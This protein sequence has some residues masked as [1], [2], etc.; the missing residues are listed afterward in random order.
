MIR[1]GS[2]AFVF[3]GSGCGLILGLDDFEDAPA[4]EDHSSSGSSGTDTCRPDISERCYSG[5]SGTEDVG[6]CSSGMRTCDSSGE[7][8]GACQNEVLP[9]QESCASTEDENCDGFDCALWAKTIETLDSNARIH[10][11]AIDSKGNTI[12]AG[13][14]AGSIQFG[15]KPLIGSE[16]TEP[17]ALDAFIVSFDSSGSHRWSRQFSD[18]MNQ[19][20]TAVCVDGS[21]NVIVAGVNSGRIKLGGAEIGPGIFVAKF[22]SGG[23]HLWSRGIA[24]SP[25]GDSGFLAGL[26][27]VKSTPDGDLILAGHFTGTI[28]FDDTEFSTYPADSQDVYIARLDGNTG[29]L[30][31]ADGGWA[32]RFEGQGNDTLAGITVHSSNNIIVTGNFTSRIDFDNITPTIDNGMFL[33]NLDRTGSVTWARGFANAQPTALSVDTLGNISATGAYEHPTNFGGGDLPDWSKKAFA[34]QFNIAGNYRWSRGFRGNITTSDISADPLNNVAILTYVTHEVRLE[35]SEIMYAREVPSPLIIKLD[36]DGKTLWKRWFPA[37][38]SGA[39]LAG[40]TETDS[41]GEIVISGHT[42]Y[43]SD[44]TATIDFGSGP[45]PM[46]SY[47]LFIAKLGS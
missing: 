1:T 15:A 21:G 36:T 16:H 14:F 12:A 30:R 13:S 5:P 42:I 44:R 33:V 25:A 32:R 11:I 43:T 9:H 10:S 26:P 47:S 46:G 6:L 28:Q 23:D 4:S 37:E 18:G 39:G 17:S 20:A 29:S 22:N 45:Q 7:M 2:L 24:G 34:V 41:S 19:E 3:A 40:V 35:E 38:P 27:K 31:S 8:W